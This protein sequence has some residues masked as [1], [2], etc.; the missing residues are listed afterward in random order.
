MDAQSVPPNSRN[1]SAPVRR[2][3]RAGALDSY[4]CPPPPA[5]L[6]I[7]ALQTCRSCRN[8]LWLCAAVVTAPS[9]SV[10]SP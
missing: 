8:K 6:S 9:L 1:C 4:T 5:L 2:V 7:R 3:G 10:S